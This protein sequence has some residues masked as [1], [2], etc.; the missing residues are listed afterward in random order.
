GRRPESHGARPDTE[1]KSRPRGSGPRGSSGVAAAPRSGLNPSPLP[2]RPAV[3]VGGQRRAGGRASAGPAG[4]GGGG[5][6]EP[7]PDAAY[8][9]PAAPAG[10]AL[11]HRLVPAPLGPCR[12]ERGGQHPV[13]P[14]SPRSSTGA[15]A[16]VASGRRAPLAAGGRP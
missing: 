3:L 5:G 1:Q 4:G 16:F 7:V 13:C 2:A 6:S 15:P 9:L 11:L 10:A 12:P 8:S 14:S